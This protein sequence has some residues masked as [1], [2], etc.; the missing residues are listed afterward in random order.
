[1]VPEPLLDSQNIQA[2]ADQ[3]RPMR[4]PQQVRMNIKADFLAQPFEEVGDGGIGHWSSL[5]LLP[6]VDE[7]VIAI[8]LL[9]FVN[10]VV[11]VE[12]HQL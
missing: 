1:M 2:V 9:K 12:P 4:M 8:S 3:L 10:Q 6:K 5:R 7:D 11:G